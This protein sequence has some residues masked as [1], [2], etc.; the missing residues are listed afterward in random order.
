MR[1]REKERE[2]EIKGEKQ[3]RQLSTARGLFVSLVASNF[4]TTI[5]KLK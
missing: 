5:V 3:M 2:R 4:G 1:E